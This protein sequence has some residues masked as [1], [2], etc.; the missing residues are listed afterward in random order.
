M[1]DTYP[2]LVGQVQFHVCL[3]RPRFW[4]DLHFLMGLSLGGGRLLL[5]LVCSKCL[6]GSSVVLYWRFC[7]QL[8]SFEYNDAE[9]IDQCLG[10]CPRVEVHM[11]N[12][13]PSRSQSPV[14]NQISRLFS[15]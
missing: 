14:T 13:K 3:S 10:D 4:S 11:V 8:V 7:C 2:S 6:W 15:V 9:I 1:W 5:H 12:Q